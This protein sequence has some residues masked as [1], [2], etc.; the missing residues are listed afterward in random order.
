MVLQ[1]DKK[2]HFCGLALLDGLGGTAIAALTTSDIL[3]IDTVEWEVLLRQKHRRDSDSSLMLKT[4]SL[5]DGIWPTC[6][7][8]DNSYHDFCILSFERVD[9]LPS[10]FRRTSP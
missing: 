2:Q 3:V 4:L 5:D 7:L 10:N 9:H 1:A 6:Q 8:T